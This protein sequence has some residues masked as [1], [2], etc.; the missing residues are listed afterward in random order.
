MNRVLAGAS[1]KTGHGNA[2]C[3]VKTRLDAG[4]RTPR[5][6]LFS[7]C[8]AP[9]ILALAL[10][11]PLQ[12]GIAGLEPPAKPSAAAIAASFE[13]QMRQVA[14][15]N[16][17]LHRGLKNADIDAL[18]HGVPN[19]HAYSRALATIHQWQREDSPEAAHRLECFLVSAACAYTLAPER[20]STL[21][22][23]FFE[24]LEQEEGRELFLCGLLRTAILSPELKE[25]VVTRFL[26][27]DFS[28]EAFE[29][30]LAKQYGRLRLLA[31]SQPG[32]AAEYLL[33]AC[34]D[35]DSP[36]LAA[37]LMEQG[38]VSEA[39][40]RAAYEAYRR[41][42]P[43]TPE[44]RAEAF[45][46]IS[47]GFYL[48]HYGLVWPYPAF[49]RSSRLERGLSPLWEP[50]SSANPAVRAAEQLELV[51]R[52][53]EREPGAGNMGIVHL[54][55]EDEVGGEL[56][57]L[58]VE[59]ELTPA[60]LKL[61]DYSFG[62]RRNAQSGD[63]DAHLYPEDEAEEL[64]DEEEAVEKEG[65]DP[66]WDEASLRLLR[67]N[68]RDI[69][70]VIASLRQSREISCQLA[71]EA[72]VNE[73]KEG[74]RAERANL[75]ELGLIAVND[76]QNPW[77]WHATF[78]IPEGDKGVSTLSSFILE[79]DC[80]VATRTWLCPYF[81]R[82]DSRDD[83][84]KPRRNCLYPPELNE[85][86]KA[87]LRDYA[88]YRKEMA[89]HH[90]KWRALLASVRDRESA[91]AALARYR[92]AG[93]ELEAIEEKY[94]KLHDAL[95][96]ANPPCTAFTREEFAPENELDAQ[97]IIR[98]YGLGFDKHDDNDPYWAYFN[99]LDRL[100]EQGC[101]GVDELN[102]L[103]WKQLHF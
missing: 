18:L 45:A 23:F 93:G 42:Q 63:L 97:A 57:C 103:I 11:L 40:L 102:R 31:P 13:A 29:Q 12:A 44:A 69:H 24:V 100:N 27:R 48:N 62:L 96:E 4:G 7:R 95:W 30:Q 54:C 65:I 6:P 87:L 72:E 56:R 36:A 73:R 90:E 60:A 39:Q 64:D 8:A 75:H 43:Y 79:G 34:L 15:H 22:R 1:E 33:Q 28:R 3:Q 38:V 55:L 92:H 32:F 25:L 35:L 86:G 16:A 52:R 76:A 20:R 70:A 83:A 59:G 101:Y 71:K 46:G 82:M 37:L 88:L 51:A 67:A 89:A 2:T 99:E 21:W 58:D 41:G 9:V 17:Q 47:Q 84:R 53:L 68:Y 50:G 91:E 5:T 66:G 19:E 94:E 81:S 98:L 49:L 80:W 14:Q 10:A 85:E 74:T 61:T 26:S 77:R 78:L